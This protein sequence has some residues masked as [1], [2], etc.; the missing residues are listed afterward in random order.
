[1]RQNKTKRMAW[2]VRSRPTK[3]AICSFLYTMISHCNPEGTIAG[4]DA[5]HDDDCDGDHV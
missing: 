4:K 2:T 5:Q 1:M 3:I